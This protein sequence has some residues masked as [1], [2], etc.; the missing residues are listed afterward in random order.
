ML[1]FHTIQELKLLSQ[2]LHCTNPTAF[3][4]TSAV[5]GT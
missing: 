5:A 3:A 4:M 2:A 1:I